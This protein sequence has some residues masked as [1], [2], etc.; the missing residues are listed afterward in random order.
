MGYPPTG[1]LF[2]S[3]KKYRPASKMLP[4]QGSGEPGEIRIGRDPLAA[5]FNGQCG[6][7]PI[8]NQLRPKIG[9]LA[10]LAKDAP[11]TRSRSDQSAS[12]PGQKSLQKPEALL[13]AG[14]R[15]EDTRVG[16]HADET[17]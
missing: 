17:V 11:V 15:I 9:G 8:R 10:E 16:D 1:A 2:A 12:W 5:A 6:M 13:R 4:A 3:L 14:R 7:N